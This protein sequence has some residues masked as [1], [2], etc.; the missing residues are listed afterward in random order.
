MRFW[1]HFARKNTFNTINDWYRSETGQYLF[2]EVVEKLNPVIATSFG[3]YSLQVG[4]TELSQRL[5]ENCRIKNRLTLGEMSTSNAIQAHPA[6]M[7]IAADSVDLVILM[8]QL[9]T[10]SEPHALLREAYRILI[11]EGRLIVVDFN[12]VSLWGLRHF[13]QSWLESVPWKGHYYTAKRLNDWMH[14][15]GF[16]QY[17][18]Y[19]AG[20]MPPI[21]QPSLTQFLGW[22]EKGMRKWLPVAG[23]LNILVYSKNIS[24]MTPIRHRW[25]TR[26]ILPGKFVRPSVGRNMK[27]EK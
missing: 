13:F 20:Y 18:H 21:L 4:C 1:R 19:R 2:D 17:R 6:L 24:P 16:D 8:H 12:P 9:S 22:L 27:Y 14:L 23:A 10:S 25:V 15:L 26:K 11:P 7:P 5:S 3:Y